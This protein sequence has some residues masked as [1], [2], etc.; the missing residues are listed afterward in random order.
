MNQLDTYAPADASASEAAAYDNAANT[1]GKLDGETLFNSGAV[2]ID[3]LLDAFNLP[4]VFIDTNGAGVTWGDLSEGEKDNW[5][6][7]AHAIRA[8]GFDRLSEDK[9]TEHA[10]NLAA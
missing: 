5:A 3:S 8:F 7:L 6:D 4:D 10:G 9:A 1:I 2:D